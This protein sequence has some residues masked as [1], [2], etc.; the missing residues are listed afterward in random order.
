LLLKGR[1]RWILRGKV[2][3]FPMAERKKKGGG[4]EVDNV[5]GKRYA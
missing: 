4:R 3:D 5:A 1:G 2:P